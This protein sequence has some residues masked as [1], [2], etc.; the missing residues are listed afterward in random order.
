MTAKE[1]LGLLSL[2]KRELAEKSRDELRFLRLDDPGTL[3]G[4]TLMDGLLL[5]NHV[6]KA[7]FD[8]T[9]ILVQLESYD[10]TTPHTA[11]SYQIRLRNPRTGTTKTVGTGNL[12]PI[13]DRKWP[14][15][16]K[17][18]SSELLDDDASKSAT[19]WEIGIRVINGDTL[20][21]TTPQYLSI[22]VDRFQPYKNKQTGV[23]SNPVRATFTNP[24]PGKDLDS[25]WLLRNTHVE[26]NISTA[27]SYY[28]Q[29]D[30]VEVWFDDTYS[31]TAPPKEVI[32]IPLPPSGQVR[33][34]VADIPVPLTNGT[35][36]LFYRLKDLVGN[37]SL[38]S[39]ERTIT[40]RIQPDAV[41][42][43]VEI[44]TAIKPD[45]LDLKDLAGRVYAEVP[46]PDNG[47]NTD[48]IKLYLAPM[49]GGIPI[50]VGEQDLGGQSRLQFELY[51]HE[52]LKP[53]FG[54]SDIE[55]EV[56]AYY[57][58]IR[59]GAP[60]RT[61]MD[62]HAIID[63]VTAGPDKG[64]ELPDLVSKQMAKVTVMGDSL[65]PNK[66]TAED[67]KGPVWIST[68]MRAT[69]DTWEPEANEQCFLIYAGHKIG[70]I[71][72][73]GGET[74][75]KRQIP[76]SIIESVGP[77]F[78][79]ASWDI[80]YV[81]GRNTMSSEPQEVEVE[82]ERITFLQ[83][84]FPLNAK[85]DVN[86]L[87]FDGNEGTSDIWLP[88]TVKIISAYMP[89]GTIVTVHSY[90]AKELDGTD[91]IPGTEFKMPYQIQGSEPGGEFVINI[92]Y[93]KY[94]KPIQPTQASGLPSGSLTV[95]FEVPVA[96]EPVPSDRNRK[97]VTLLS[98]ENYC[99]GTPNRRR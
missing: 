30:E 16:V 67:L 60:P 95:W 23:V 97:K 80:Q 89:A 29:D 77:G 2:G 35:W 88:V 7:L 18:L 65:T 37:F 68:P 57:E 63:F 54:T 56:R 81:D 73:R 5:E 93:L 34:P 10:S 87:S 90:G 76:A 50:F 13:A 8:L 53:L 26:C 4:K 22:K 84:T 49:T 21:P 41:L 40:V 48:I 42:K 12:G 61:S 24:A 59:R 75:I 45:A 28:R 14:L 36:Y 96:G 17:F 85:G 99:E 32:K 27:F 86:C 58:F 6:P 83:P 25:D 66:I 52:H 1:N 79:N 11:D 20:N 94:I 64:D 74:E 91:V 92:P 38:V 78:H 9:D 69:G 71:L 43:P 98:D 82:K 39:L 51:Y 44:P 15:E 70:P 55:V 62:T 3:A 47:L 46:R 72:L 33:F 31:Q 19:D